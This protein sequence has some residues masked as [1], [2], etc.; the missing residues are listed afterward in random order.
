MYISCGGLGNSKYFVYLI[1]FFVFHQSHQP[2]TDLEIRTSCLCGGAMVRATPLL[3]DLGGLLG[4]PSCDP[5]LR[6]SQRGYLPP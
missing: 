5:H 6:L 2:P 4:S 1:C 3:S